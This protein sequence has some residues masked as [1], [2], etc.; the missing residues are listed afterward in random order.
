[1]SVDY[2]IFLISEKVLM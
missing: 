1:M 2:K